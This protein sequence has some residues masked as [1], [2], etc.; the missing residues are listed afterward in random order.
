M[1]SVCYRLS[2][3]LS[4]GQERPL[5][6]GQLPEVLHG[7]MH[8]GRRRHTQEEGWKMGIYHPLG[9]RARGINSLR[10]TSLPVWQEDARRPYLVC[11][12]DE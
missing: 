7:A 4:G 12:E 3:R 6:A 2:V 10:P 1:L 8:N 11:P 9:S 5:G